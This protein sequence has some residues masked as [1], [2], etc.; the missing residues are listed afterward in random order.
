[1]VLFANQSFRFVFLHAAPDA[2]HRDIFESEHHHQRVYDNQCYTIVVPRMDSDAII[3][4]VMDL[5]R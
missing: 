3:A 1:M 5:K 2:F 4:V